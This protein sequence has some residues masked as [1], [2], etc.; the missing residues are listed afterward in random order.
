MLTQLGLRLGCPAQEVLEVELNE[1][2]RGIRF[3]ETAA[4]LGGESDG[5][6]QFSGAQ[7]ALG[8]TAFSRHRP[9]RFHQVGVAHHL[10]VSGANQTIDLIGGVTRA[11]LEHFLL[12][13]SQ[14]ETDVGVVADRGGIS[15]IAAGALLGSE[16]RIA[17]HAA[18]LR[19]A[20][21]A[22][23]GGQLDVGRGVACQAIGKL[24]AA[25]DGTVADGEAA[26][27]RRHAGEAVV[28]D[29]SSGREGAGVRHHVVTKHLGVFSAIDDEID[30]GVVASAR[31]Q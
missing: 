28:G 24:A 25:A 29:A 26:F 15:T 17:A 30:H 11:A 12:P 3:K 6:N 20:G 19:A 7:I 18:G 22:G 14:A 4:V 8:V 31:Q 5:A 16:L 23:S 9:L 13:L 27:E 1:A 10:A 21:E 2:V